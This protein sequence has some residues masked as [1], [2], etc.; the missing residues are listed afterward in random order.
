MTKANDLP[1]LLLSLTLDFGINISNEASDPT[2][3]K[4]QSSH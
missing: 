2:E 3:F 1:L 4:D